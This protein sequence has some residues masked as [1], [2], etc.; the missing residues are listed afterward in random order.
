MNTNSEETKIAQLE[1]TMKALNKSSL[2]H[3]L[4][5]NEA[6]KLIKSLE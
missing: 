1:K 5:L 4:L 2:K 6:S 3:L